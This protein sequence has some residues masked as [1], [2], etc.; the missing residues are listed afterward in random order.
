MI[1]WMD[2]PAGAG[3]S[4]RGETQPAGREDATE[5]EKENDKQ[6]QIM[7]ALRSER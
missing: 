3:L 1:G 5:E 2:T 6:A 4:L 7:R